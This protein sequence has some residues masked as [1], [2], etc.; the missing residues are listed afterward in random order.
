MK[1]FPWFVAAA[2]AIAFV[3]FSPGQNPPARPAGAAPPAR[4]AIR[5]AFGERQE[6]ETDYSGTLQLSP[7]RVIELIPYRFFGTDGLTGADGWRL[8]TRRAN[9]EN[10]PDQPRP[11]ATAGAN[12]NIVPKAVAAILEAPA[13]ANATVK[14]D[15][16]T[17]TFRLDALANGR[18]LSFEDGDVLVQSV[19]GP[20]R[21]SPPFPAGNPNTYPDNDY[22]S[23]AIASDGTAWT[24]WQVYENGGDRVLAAHSTASGWTAPDALTPAGQD[25]FHTAIALDS[26]GRVWVVWSQREGE[27]WELTAR[28]YDGQ[29]WSAARRITNANGPNFFHKLVRGRDG[30]LHLV[31]IAHLNTQSH[32]MWSK[33]AGDAWSAPQ[34]ISGASAWMPDAA[35][36][37]KGNLYIAWDSYRTGNY[38][39]FLRR[40]NPD[41]SM[42]PIQQVTKSSRFQAHASLAV[43]GQD[44]VWL[45]WDESGANWGKDY[46]RDDTWRGTTLYADR[47]P[48]VAVLENGQWREPAGDPMAAVPRRFNR[49]VENPLLAC[50]AAGRIWMLASVRTSTAMNRADFWANNGRWDMFLTTYDG[51][52][53][54]DAAQIPKSSTRPDGPVQLAVSGS[55]VWAVW[56]NDNRLFPA[57]AGQ[58]NRRHN[59]IDFAR[60]D[61]APA[62]APPVLIAFT[63]PPA[64][65]GFVHPHEA[66]DVRQIREYRT[67][68]DGAAL[69]I[70]RGDFHRHTEISPDGA[71]DGSLDDYFRYMIDAASMDTGIVSDH[72]AGV[73]EYTWWRTEK[74]ID[75]YHIPGGYTPLFGYERSVPYPNGHRNV[76]FA[77]RG[78]HVLP[79][80]QAENQNRVNTGPI[81]YP[82]LKQNRGIC[83][84]HSLATDQGSDYRDNDP[85]VEPLVE[86]YQGYH[87]NYEYAGA[88]RA[89][90]DNYHVEA[91]G[92]YRPAGFYWTALAKGLKLGTESSSDHISTHT[93][94]SMIYT[95][96]T[97]RRDIVESMRKRHAYGAT[98]NIVLDF[99]MRTRDGKEGMMGDVLDA[100]APPVLHVKVLGTS[101]IEAIDVI[102]D[103]KFVYQTKNG[104][105]DFT[106]TA[107]GT[108]TSWYYVRVMQADR[109][110]AWSSP[111]WVNWK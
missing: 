101:A 83:M 64:N 67:Q 75:L 26:R 12:Q 55:G 81:L 92:P 17:Y 103:G 60:V 106:D 59:E 73:E 11:L 78:V 24:A 97:N 19:P 36:D 82:Y 52:R 9:F 70:M 98:D 4:T 95:P 61:G 110:M 44:R 1:R 33:L 30:T 91:H 15:R 77:E 65:A 39:I 109:A 72:N 8:T 27:A 45:A 49:Y 62:P 90:S 54:R 104:E 48:R 86:I 89:E 41:G 51:D 69:R 66:A 16:G 58:P 35:A 2:A 96:T 47:R 63:E 28:T 93:S 10:Q 85:E 100:A 111:I 43:D 68:A 18:V 53:W 94:Y 79:I 6:H 5:I 20:E 23:L 76:V 57:A 108:G 13:G 3:S 25:V 87:A 84:L 46:A 31:W 99:R 40:V 56:T 88:P 14:T 32:V 7:G 80:S 105:F 107:K 42:E 38:D 74:A 102:K 22:P 71:G 37:S 29:S 34:E 50:D 21:V